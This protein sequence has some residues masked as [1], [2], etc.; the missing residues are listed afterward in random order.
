M[1]PRAVLIAQMARSRG[2]DPAAVLS[3]ASVEGGFNG[4]IG[5]HGTS[6][7]PFQLHI[8][9]ALPKGISNP[10]AWANSKAGIGYALDHISQVAGGLHGK[11]AIAAISSR[12]ERPADVPGEIAKASGRYGQFAGGALPKGSIGPLSGGLGSGA[13]PSI[14]GGGANPAALSLLEQSMAN[15]GNIGGEDLLAFALQRQQSQ[16]A[17]NTFGPTPTKGPLVNP[18]TGGSTAFAGNLSG[19]NPRFL[20]ALQSAAS[21]AGATKIRVISGYRSPAHNASVGGV[22]HSLHTRGD[23][24]DGEAYVPGKGWI[25]LGVLLRPIASKYGLQSGDQ[26]GFFNGGPDPNH[27]DFAPSL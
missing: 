22:P 10:Q 8:G 18:P 20:K 4:S 5:D 13:V 6:F 12:F 24:M 17:Q 26:P 7:G 25:P 16:A 15:I 14:S 27:V 23:A 2:L 3:I 19:E 9:G 11:Q 21:A 1:N